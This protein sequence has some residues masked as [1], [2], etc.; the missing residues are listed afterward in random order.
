VD[1]RV[2]ARIETRSQS[3]WDADEGISERVS[4]LPLLYPADWLNKTPPKLA[5]VV[6]GWLSSGSAGLLSGGPAVGKS[7]LAQTLA[8]CVATAHPF[9][10]IP[11]AYAPA[12]YVTCEDGP[13]ELW[14]R[15]ES[16]NSALGLTMY[17]LDKLLLSSLK[18]EPGN[19]LGTFD[20]HGIFR[21]SERMRAIEDV[22]RESGARLIV[23]D[24][25][26]HLF[27]GNENSRPEVAAFCN[28]MDRLAMRIGGSVLFLG[29]PNKAGAE[30]SGSTGWDAHVRHRLFMDWRPSDDAGIA[31]PDARVLRRSMSNYGSRGEEIA[32]R[33]HQGAFVLEK[34][35]PEQHRL[36]LRATTQASAENARFHECLAKA[37]ADRRNVSHVNGSNYAPRI[38]ARMP[39]AQGMSTAAFERAMERLLHLGEIQ[40]DQPLWRGSNRVMKQGIKATSD[41]TD[42]PALTPCTDP[43]EPLSQVIEN[44]ASTQCARPPLYTSYKEGAP[45]GAAAPSFVNEPDPAADA[46]LG[47][48][49]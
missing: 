40:V 46:Y 16:I 22:A 29:H 35:L 15:Q 13:D 23:L 43:H 11:V 36:D 45:L 49:Q 9:L 26:A 7:L 24:N 4:G 33:W 19:E 37:T 8:T 39:E 38:F 2:R 47:G 31:D 48:R 10:G 18:G 30:Y 17:G 21:P 32:F 6:A 20:D 27:P 28:A 25:V 44:A 12:L 42:P 1:A 5:W 34:D 41:C 14:R 3:S